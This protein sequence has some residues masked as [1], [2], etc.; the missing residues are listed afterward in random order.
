MDSHY[1]NDTSVTLEEHMAAVAV[2]QGL[3]Q[4]YAALFEVQW[5]SERHVQVFKTAEGK[6]PVGR[7]LLNGERNSFIEA[8]ARAPFSAVAPEAP[9]RTAET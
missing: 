9:A 1:D 5:V 3:S 4:L 2:Q 6:Y 7:D 8:V